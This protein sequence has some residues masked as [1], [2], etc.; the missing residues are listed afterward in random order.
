M[1]TFG[2]D[3]LCLC[4]KLDLDVRKTG[5]IVRSLVLKSKF[6]MEPGCR[7]ANQEGKVQK[8]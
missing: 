8:R 4:G 3:L 7:M 1:S 6:L 2:E 5:L